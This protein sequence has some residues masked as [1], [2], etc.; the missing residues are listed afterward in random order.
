MDPISKVATMILNTR[1]FTLF[2]KVRQSI[3]DYNGMK[4]IAFDT[5][6]KSAFV[7]QH[8]VT[9]YIPSQYKQM[10]LQLIIGV[11]QKNHPELNHP[12]K[13]L[14]KSTFT[15]EGPNF[16]GGR[17]RIGDQIVMVEGS[18]KFME[19][20][21]LFPA[22]FPFEVSRNW[23]LTIRG[24]KRLDQQQNKEKDELSDFSEQFRNSVLVE[25]AEE[26]MRDAGQG[27]ASRRPL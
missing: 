21:A 18:K 5:Y 10:P 14:E 17:S 27:G 7:A 22:R 13:I 23:K 9:L 25:A 2:K 15:T 24:G 26:M 12:Y 16:K 1:N 19:G 3:R 4:G 8:G 6:E 11:I 20:L